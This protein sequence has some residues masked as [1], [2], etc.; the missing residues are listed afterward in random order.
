MPLSRADQLPELALSVRQPWA[1]AIVAGHKTIENRS[2]GSIRAGNITCRTI[3]IHA[4]S[5]MREAEYRWAYWKMRQIGV[6]VPPPADLV[7]SAITGVVDVVDIIDHSTSPWFGG[8]F[9][10]V[11]ENARSIAP[12]PCKGELGYFRWEESGEISTAPPWMHKYVTDD[13]FGTFDLTFK[14]PPP[15]PFG[16]TKNR[17][18]NP[19]STD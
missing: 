16:G 19:Q 8:P 10:L 11:L 12:I 3:C 14:E 7:R 6:S 18:I 17:K 4:A 2:A 5:G 1:W 13:L 15:K 9:G